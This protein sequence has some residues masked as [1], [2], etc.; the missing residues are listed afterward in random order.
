MYASIAI[1]RAVADELWRRHGI[2]TTTFR[3]RV[4]LA[5]EE[6][7]DPACLLPL[8]RYNEVLRRAR[9]LVP[10]DSDLGLHVGESAPANAHRM[11]QLLMVCRSIRDGIQLMQRYGGLVLEDARFGVHETGERAVFSFEHP[12]VA[13][14]NARHEAEG[15]LAFT[16]RLGQRFTGGRPALR[17]RFAHARPAR[18]DE[19]RRV[20]GCEVEFGAPAH[21]IEFDRGGLDRAN[22]HADPHLCEVLQGCADRWLADRHADTRLPQRVLDLARY[23]IEVAG[24]GVAAVARRLGLSSRTLQRK[25]RQQGVCLSELLDRA[26][27]QAACAAL[28][29]PA[30]AVK[31]LSD[32]LGFSDPS[33]FHRAFKRWTGTTPHRYRE[34]LRAGG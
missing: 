31:D 18:I 3:E 23:E 34:S 9:A 21:Q 10:H 20:F 30:T 2:A 17:V 6:L 27:R 15:L 1:V 26:R 28:A 12:G 7:A 22:V 13:P 25:L 4:G 8:P 11:T 16:Y 24:E 14:D 5:R 32:R 29:D 19:H 33:A